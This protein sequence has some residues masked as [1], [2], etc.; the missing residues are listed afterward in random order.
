VPRYKA[1]KRRRLQAGLGG[2]HGQALHFDIF[3]ALLA[4]WLPLMNFF[5]SFNAI[6]CLVQPPG[7][8]RSNGTGNLNTPTKW[9]YLLFLV[10]C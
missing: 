5:S 8:R 3:C 4:Q 7:V 10:G 1:A 2:T 6:Q 9:V